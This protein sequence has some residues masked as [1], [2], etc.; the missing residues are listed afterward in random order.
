MPSKLLVCRFK[1]KTEYELVLSAYSKASSKKIS[2]LAIGPCNEDG[3][4][5]DSIQHSLKNYF[6]DKKNTERTC[7]QALSR[8]LYPG[9]PEPNT[10]HVE[11]LKALLSSLIY[12]GSDWL[13]RCIA[14][15]WGATRLGWLY[16]RD[17][18]LP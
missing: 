8:K 11:L 12:T 3:R 17:L 9:H 6:A 18:T 7:L 4:W 10:G 13:C 16:G 2:V 15:E 14:R 5:L 1:A